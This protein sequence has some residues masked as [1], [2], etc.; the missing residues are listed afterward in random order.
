MMTCSWAAQMEVLCQQCGSSWVLVTGRDH[1][2]GWLK[3]IMRG[4]DG[5]KSKS[6]ISRE[7]FKQWLADIIPLG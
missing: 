1:C 2:S 5:F 4:G 7:G 6:A 3:R